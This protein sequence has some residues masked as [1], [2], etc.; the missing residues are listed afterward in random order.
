MPD[1]AYVSKP[2]CL[3]GALNVRDLGNYPAGGG[4]K[5]RTHMFLRSDSLAGLSEKDKAFLYD[6][7]VRCIIDMRDEAEIAKQP[8]SIP[9]SID[10]IN[11]PL[12]DSIR[13]ISED[14]GIPKTMREFYIKFLLDGSMSGIA[15]VLKKAA[16]YPE[17]C[18][19]FNCTAGKD[20]TGMIAMLLLKLA[21]VDNSDIIADY[22][23]SAENM[24]PILD[25]QRALF[26]SSGRETAAYLL[27][28][29]PEEMASS[30]G[31]LEHEYGSANSYMLHIGL[32]EQTIERLRGKLVKDA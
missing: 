6:Y 25:K 26:L 13:A 4:L 29:A 20:R 27:D 9:D 3:D 30:I 7:G 32:S 17:S 14:S 24:K 1:T 5:T 16:E 2:L 19:L 28:A 10:Y 31:Y 18:V 15:R 22:A 21:G 23:A 11:I 8:F 12:I